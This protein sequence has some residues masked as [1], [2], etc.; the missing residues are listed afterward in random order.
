MDDN[1]IHLPTK[2]YAS[3]LDVPLPAF[4]YERLN[5]SQWQLP[6][7][8]HHSKMSGSNIP[9]APGVWAGF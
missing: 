3:V 8:L 6:A 9:S 1:V 2:K 4:V 7:R 5:S